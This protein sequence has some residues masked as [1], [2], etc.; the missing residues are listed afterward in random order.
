[1]AKTKLECVAIGDGASDIPLFDYCGTSVAI[2]YS[3]NVIGKATYY[4]KTNDLSKI[5][6]YII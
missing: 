1:M 6:K 5:L 3:E 2:N 4:S